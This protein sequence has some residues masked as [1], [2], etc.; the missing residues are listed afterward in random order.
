MECMYLVIVK[1]LIRTF[2]KYFLGA[3]YVLGITPGVKTLVVGVMERRHTL[4]K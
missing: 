1:V 3:W 4:S 2:H